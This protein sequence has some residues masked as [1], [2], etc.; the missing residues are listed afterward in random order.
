[1]KLQDAYKPIEKE[2]LEV[3]R[4]I[5]EQFQDSDAQISSVLEVLCTQRG[6]MIR[7]AMTLLCGRQF[8]QICPEHI[9]LAAMVELVHMASLLHDD[10]ID[11]AQLRRGRPSAN[12]LWGNTAAVLL[13]DLLL[14]RA[15]L[16]ATA[17][18]CSNAVLLLGQ[19]AQ[20]LCVGE[21]K[22]NLLKG[23]LD[24]TEQEYFQVTEAK[25]ASLFQCSCL[26]GAMVS[27]APPDQQ[28]ALGLFGRQFGLAFQIADDLRDILSSEKTEGKTLGTDFLQKKLTLPVIHWIN[29]NDE[30]KQSRMQ[31]IV[32]L[33]DPEALT[34][35]LRLSGSIDYALEQ[36]NLR[37]EQAKQSLEQLSPTPSKEALRLFADQV[38]AAVSKHFNVAHQIKKGRQ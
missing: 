6:K 9:T 10:V 38:G 32:S 33:E 25:T 27:N 35:Q 16:L 19:T 18:K 2:L 37:I 31:Q 13:G 1:M 12:A 14:S 34:E 28:K 21:L 20:G 30:Q 26:L 36:A 22:Q 11:K 24:L 5:S 23:R 17:S 29:Q 15:F 3:Q 4:K 7:P 8:S